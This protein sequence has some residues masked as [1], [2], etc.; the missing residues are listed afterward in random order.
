MGIGVIVVCRN[1]MAL[2]IVQR[3]FLSPSSPVRFLKSRPKAVLR[4][5]CLHIRNYFI[6]WP[7]Q[8]H[9]MTHNTL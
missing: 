6:N 4:H 2:Y 1:I 7:L 5:L 9:D 8:K 3:L